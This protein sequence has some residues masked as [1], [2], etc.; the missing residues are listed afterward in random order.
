MAGDWRTSAGSSASTIVCPASVGSTSRS[1][2]DARGP[3]VERAVRLVE[4]NA[5]RFA[6]VIR[7][8]P[9]ATGRLILA[10]DA[11]DEIVRFERAMRTW[12][13]DGSTRAVLARTNRELLPAVIVALGLG[14]PFRAPRIDLP[15][16]SPIVDSLLEEA[17]ARRDRG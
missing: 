14:V 4:H 1:T 3:V 10:P 2:I 16:E 8:G 11:S 5:E 13:D 9:G 17:A 12:P 15:L 7:P 6:K